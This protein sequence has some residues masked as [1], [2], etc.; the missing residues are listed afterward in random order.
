MTQS[1]NPN[2]NQARLTQVVELT[3]DGRA[4]SATLGDTILK[5]ARAYGMDIPSLCADPRLKP[6]A[7]CGLC[8]V[9]IEGGEL[10]R[11]CETAVVDGMRVVTESPEIAEVRKERLNEFLSNHNAYCE[12]PCH[13]AC[14]AGLDIPGYIA[15]IARGDDAECVRIVKERLP[16]PRIIGRVCP[17]P[18]EDACR[19]TQVDGKPIAICQLK[20]F[21]SDSVA[22]DGQGSA[23]GD[24]TARPVSSTGKRVAVIG[25]GPSGLSAAYFLALAG[26]DATIFE[27]GGEPGGMMLTGIPPYRLPRRVIKDEVEDIL[28]TGVKLELNQRLGTDFTL[29]ELKERGFDAVYL[30]IGAAK[31]MDGG[32]EGGVG[33]GAYSA[34]EFLADSNAGRWSR[35]LGKTV[36]IGGGF[37][38]IDAARSAARL[39]ADEVNVVYRRTQSEMPATRDEVEAAQAEGV[40]FS[41]LTAPCSVV[42][43]G[44]E[45]A[46]IV[47]QLMELGEPDE[48]GRRRPVPVS[49]SDFTTEADTIIFAIGQKVDGGGVE[50]RVPLKKNGT[51][52]ADP[53]TLAAAT[54]GVFAG[55]DCATGPATV[56]EAIAAGRRAATAIDAY[57][58]GED[59]AEACFAPEKGLDRRPPKFFEIGAKPLSTSARAHMP[60]LAVERRGGFDEVELGF[61]EDQA[62]A[63]ASRCL[64]C[65]C[66]AASA[67]GLQRLSIQYGAG[68]TEFAGD[69]G[70]FPALPGAPI[71]ELDRKRCI[72][73][74]NCVRICDE[75]QQQH[76]YTTDDAGYPAFRVGGT[77]REAGCVSCGQCV[78]ACPTGAIK[79]LT[80]RG[81]LRID[82]R[83]KLDTTCPYCGV[84]CNFEV[85][86]EGERVVAVAADLNTPVNQ[87]NLCVKGRYGFSFHDHPDRL[88]KPL[89]R[90]S[91]D[92][93]FREVEWDGAL[94]YVAKNF[95]RIIEESGPDAMGVLTSSRGLNEENYAAQK[96]YR[97]VIGTNNVDNC[98][99]VCHAPSVAGLYRAFGSGAATNPLS[100]IQ[101]AD[102]L[103]MVGT[104]TNEG[105]P[106]AGVMVKQ[107][108]SCGAKSIVADPRRIESAERA[109]HFLNLKAGTNVALLNGLLNVIIT[110]GLTDEEFIASRTENFGPTK[111]I[112]SEY[113]PEKVEEITGVPADDIRAAARAYAQ[114]ENAMILY[115]LGVTE[116]RYGSYGVM[117]LANLAMATGNV[118]KPGAGII[119]LRGQNNVQG[120]CDMGAL[121]EYFTGYQRIADDASRAKFEQA[122][123]CALSATTGLKEPEM[124][125][126]AIDGQLKSLHV[127]GYDPAKTQGNLNFVHE[128][129]DA[130]DFVVVQDI[131]MTETAKRANVILPAACY[132]EKDGTFTNGERRIQ[133]VRKVI[134]PP[135]GLLPDWAIVGAIAE[136][137]GAGSGLAFADASAI[138]DE[139]ASVTPQF[140]GVSYAR[141]EKEQLHWPVWSAEDKG[142]PM[143]HHGNFTKGLG[144]FHDIPY[145]PSDEKTDE[146]FPLLMTTGRRLYHYCN[147]SM[148]LRTPILE[149]CSEENLEISPADAE[150]YGIVDGQSVRVKSRRGEVVL[151]ANVTERSL[152]GSLFTSFHFDAP[153]TNFLTGPGEDEL[154]LTPEYKVCAVAVE[155]A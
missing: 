62:R 145:V 123:G 26:H 78:S 100:D 93:D 65:T 90:E 56:V 37:T 55:G 75:V 6:A 116:H 136:K 68:T 107:A 126:A 25:S 21:A 39:G 81:A 98:A 79:D 122:W 130:V 44:G 85:Q 59:T 87:G 70:F 31:G 28:K 51:V 137:M 46:G 135:E 67:C 34:V 92:Q 20:R 146:E 66:H 83:K 30:A 86:V 154:A 41:F 2:G 23:A 32:V 121:P 27:A 97:A 151:T 110:E 119:V 43:E 144:T 11:A 140:T 38:A 118:G 99:R 139:V 63:E 17:R 106:V 16:L 125:R 69:T 47:C 120:S 112:V 73:C 94:E 14:P 103:L 152:P 105:H 22:R 108:L 12:P 131:F 96:F 8:V 52:I 35:P 153:L 82:L 18:C 115:G 74:H 148:T 57:V 36:V 72:K 132:F 127:I 143:L 155:R 142:S 15:A 58:A 49:D 138:M 60:E 71:L 4:V 150:K 77:Y 88:K 113:T 42:R 33:V 24:D 114:A 147:G 101:K 3:I 54:E 10:L 104:N 109:D 5:A 50:G 133:R 128:A 40:K 141:L 149:L 53:V 1:P 89:M 9:R 111:Q 95:A 91:R 76:V 7:Q 124:Y 134:E 84:G 102:L 129:Y 64:Q 48:S 29:D 61:S 19:R 117:C 13:Y 45:V 80:D